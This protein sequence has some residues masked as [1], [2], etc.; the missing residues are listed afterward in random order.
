M[1][2]S[3]QNKLIVVFGPTSSGK[4]DLALRIAKFIWGRMQIQSEFINADSRQVYKDMNIGASRVGKTFQKKFPYHL[5]QILEPGK[6]LDAESYKK[7]ALQKIEEIHK[8]GNL[9]ILE[10]GTGTYIMS[11]VGDQFIV[12]P[13]NKGVGKIFEALF[14]I[15]SFNRKI[16]Y[17]KIEKSVDKMF[18]DGLYKEVKNIIIIYGGRTDIL[19]GTIGY[20]QF[21]EYCLRNNAI[22]TKLENKDLKRIAW[23]IKRDTKKYAMHQ[24]AWLKKLKDYKIVREFK[25]I[26]N[27]LLEF[28]EK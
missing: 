14:F 22:I 20:R 21:V 18:Q 23:M 10:G 4:T 19:G 15:P 28:V 9:P 5:A 17:R 25:N 7:L 13:R 16:L 24:I 3:V 27:L 12:N 26:E 8:R 11:V 1:A 6:K 2:I